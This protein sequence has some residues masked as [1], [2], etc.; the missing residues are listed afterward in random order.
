MDGMKYC[1]KHMYW[2]PI[3]E[4]CESCNMLAK[5]GCSMPNK[6]NNSEDKQ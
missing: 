6:L 3:E 2:F 4:G 5:V 1:T